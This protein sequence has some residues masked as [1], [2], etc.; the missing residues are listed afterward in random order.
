MNFNLNVSIKG[1]VK[2]YYTDNGEILLD[3]DNSVHSQ[4]MARILAR[5]LAHEPN[6]WISR[7][8]FGNGG[9]RIDAIGNIIFNPP[10]D[11][12][13]GSWESRLYNETYSEVVD[14]INSSYGLDLGSS[15]PNSTRPGGG[16]DPSSDPDGGGV[17]S[18]EVGTKSNVIVSITLNENEPS[19]QALVS[20]QPTTED[21]NC[22]IFDEIGLYCPGKP[23]KATYGLTTVNVGN[24]NSD[25]YINLIPNSVLTFN[26][27]VNGIELSCQITVPNSGSGPTGQITYGD[28]CEG[29]NN[30]T[31]ITGG[32]A[33]YNNLYV[34]ITDKSEGT[35]PSIIGK[36]SY[37]LLIF[38]SKT[39]GNTSS[40][41]VH[42]N[43][44]GINDLMRVITGNVCANCN[45]S[46]INGENAGVQN[47][48]V[49]PENERERLLTHI[50]FNPI[51]KSQDRAI[52]ITYTLTIS[53]KNSETLVEVIGS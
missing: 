38:Q 15:D 41:L 8:A 26:V 31:W 36:Q 47:D 21:E 37:G 48:P 18:Q 39:T 52:A 44:L 16:A 43:P 30:G 5:A 53:V 27:N 22:F 29:I 13:D 6:S 19:G 7:M 28:F 10:N 42:C 4:N 2:A 35:Y 17:I 50:I 51:L 45:I 9:T 1:H 46:T 23:A 33:I 11:G 20:T 49:H 14:E 24:K 34:Y 40:I 3:K 32:D 12:R 25:D